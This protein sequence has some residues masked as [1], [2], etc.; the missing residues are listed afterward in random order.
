M[1][2]VLEE[3]ISGKM[4]FSTKARYFFDRHKKERG[5]LARSIKDL[6]LDLRARSSPLE[7]DI[8]QSPYSYYFRKSRI[9]QNHGGYIYFSKKIELNLDYVKTSTPTKI[10]ETLLHE[11]VHAITSKRHLLGDIGHSFTF[12]KVGK[13]MGLTMPDL[14]LSCDKCCLEQGVNIW[15][16]GLSFDCS[17]GNELIS[18]GKVL[19]DAIIFINYENFRSK[20]LRTYLISALTHPYRRDPMNITINSDKVYRLAC[21]INREEWIVQAVIDRYEKY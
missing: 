10:K 20:D 6:V 8:L 19:S 11:N 17:C 2:R 13:A 4:S 1:N 9:P 14:Y 5:V 15:G 7:E 3:V 16:E 12:F 21:P 18:H